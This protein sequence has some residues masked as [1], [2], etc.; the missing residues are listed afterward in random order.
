MRSLRLLF[1]LG[2]WSFAGCAKDEPTNTRPTGPTLGQ[3][4]FGVLCDRVGAQALHEDLSGASYNDICHGTATTVD[5]SKLPAPPDANV[6]ATSVAKVEALARHKPDIIAALDTVFPDDLVVGKNLD[7]SDPAATCDPVSSKTRRDQLRGLLSRLLPKEGDET[8]PESSR[9]VARTIEPLTTEEGANARIAMTHLA[10]R[11]GYLPPELSTGLLASVLTAPRLRDLLG[12]TMTN[13]GPD[14]DPYDRP[15]TKGKGYGAFKQFIGALQ[16]DMRKPVEQEKPLTTTTDAAGRPILSRPRTA[17][18]L[19]RAVLLTENPVFSNGDPLYVVKRD[20]RGMAV[21]KKQNGKLPAPFRD[22]DDDGLPDLDSLGRFIGGGPDPFVGTSEKDPTYEYIDARATAASAMLRHLAPLADPDNGKESLLNAAE[23][24]EPLL[25]EGGR[26]ALL[27]L[28]HA[29]GNISADPGTDGALALMG[30]LFTEQPDLMARVAGN[31]LDLKAVLDAH[32]E[33][34]IPEGSTLVDDLMDVAV[35]LAAEPGLLEDILTSMSDERGQY[36]KQAI[37]AMMLNKD[38]ISY[39]PAALNGL[40]KNFTTGGG[41]PETLVDRTQPNVG[42]NRSIF[43][44][45]LGLLSDTNGVTFCNRE[46][47]RLHGYIKSPA[48]GQFV[49]IDL[50]TQL[51]ADAIGDPAP[52]CTMLKIDN[53]SVFYLQAMVGKAKLVLRNTL[54][55]DPAKPALLSPA[56]MEK[57]TGITGFWNSAKGNPD[58]RD[59]DYAYP[60]PEFLNRL[61][62]FKVDDAMSCSDESGNKLTTNC[63]IRD[64]QGSHMPSSVCKERTIDDPYFVSPPGSSLT[65]NDAVD[66]SPDKKIHGLRSCQPGENLDE[67]APDTLFALE[68][69]HGIDAFAPLAEVFVK[70]KKETLLV[71]L[72]VALNKSWSV[73]GGIASSEPALAEILKGDLITSLGELAKV[74]NKMKID[75][76]VA[77]GKNECAKHESV[78]AVTVLAEGVRALVDPARAK[79]AG[80]TDRRGKTTTKSGKPITIMG[81]LRDAINEEEEV[82]ARDKT[83][84]HQ[85]LKAR[86]NIVDEFLTINGRGADAKFADP[87]IPQIAPVIIGL[88]RAQRLAKCKSDTDCPALRQD[89]SKEMEEDLKKPVF[90]SALDLLDAVL[91]DKPMRGE[92]GRMTSYMFRA[93]GKLGGDTTASASSTPFSGSKKGPGVLDQSLAALVDALGAVG[94]L[95]DVRRMYPFLAKSLDD[96]DPQLSLL[97]RLNARAY[98]ANGNEICSKEL[99]PE[100]AIRNSLARLSLPVTVEGKPTRPALQIFLDAIA[101]VNRV[102]AS[103]DGPLEPDDYMNVFKNVHELLTDPKSGLEQL[104]ASVKNATAR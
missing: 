42:W 55:T 76:C 95:S 44:R 51:G 82:L 93:D 7:A 104:Y 22:S 33:A 73:Q 78:P 48:T 6:R 30:Q 54:Y 59:E 67:R 64:L 97:S 62:F 77:S 17:L 31:L 13:I 11:R 10:A 99:D 46:G 45:F 69:N 50:P 41:P 34:R 60:R 57:S 3:D 39:D 56:V 28:V 35:K 52:E 85:W 65:P 83:R 53:L 26:E 74:T 27:D 91:A 90:T 2:L 103:S 32:P 5:Q 19:T 38:R 101:D 87:G 61:V 1:V 72:M 70:H 9:A 100:E 8:V 79:A 68:Y 18:E 96:L 36:I 43:Q 86:S 23:G 25:R 58:G 89:L 75:R 40:P 49:P 47:A 20:Y 84:E 80:V 81:L 12:A 16:D 37:P 88:L 102:D 98:D 21:V 15:N 71:D 66:P 63:V 94:D 24:I 4:I 14:A 29:G 92:I